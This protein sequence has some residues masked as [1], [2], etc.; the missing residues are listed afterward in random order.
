LEMLCDALAL[1]VV[2]GNAHQEKS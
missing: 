2:V 1:V